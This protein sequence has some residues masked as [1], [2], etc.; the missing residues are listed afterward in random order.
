MLQREEVPPGA[1]SL[2]DVPRAEEI[3]LFEA[4]LGFMEGA[5]PPLYLVNCVVVV[6]ESE[7]VAVFPI[8]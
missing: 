6:S 8:P 2:P 4:A 3:W 7:E 1:I 5:E